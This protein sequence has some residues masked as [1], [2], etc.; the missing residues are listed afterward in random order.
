[1]GRYKLMGHEVQGQDDNAAP[2][3]R[4]QQTASAPLT[5]VYETDDNKEAETI[6]NAGGFF[7]DRD[8]F[9]AVES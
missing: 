8:N 1:M 7:R 2:L 3:T 6:V 5:V 9:I 4:E